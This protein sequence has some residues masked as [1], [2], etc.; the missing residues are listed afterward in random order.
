MGR[1]VDVQQIATIPFRRL[2]LD[3]DPLLA[4]AVTYES[5]VLVSQ[6]KF[7]KHNPEQDKEPSDNTGPFRV[8]TEK[9]LGTSNSTSVYIESKNSTP[10]YFSSLI[11]AVGILLNTIVFAYARKD[12]NRDHNKGVIDEFWYR[13]IL[14]PELKL[15]AKAFVEDNLEFWSEV[16]S[17]PVYSSSRSQNFI[18][19]RFNVHYHKVLMTVENIK[20][21]DAGFSRGEEVQ[22]LFETLEDKVVDA[23]YSMID[24]NF[25]QR[26]EK[27][28]DIIDS[29]NELEPKLIAILLTQHR[30]FSGV[31]SQESRRMRFKSNFFAL[32]QR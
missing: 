20:L 13:T 14:M 3:T 19:S 7:T 25:H 15:H 6:E 8:V 12:K 2:S 27:M 31:K 28:N 16:K 5:E 24:D 18:E 4:Q 10:L 32:F 17:K 21:I 23:S 1:N 29:V 22:T 30:E 11:A 9:P 26:L